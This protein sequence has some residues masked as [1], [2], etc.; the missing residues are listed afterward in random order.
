LALMHLVGILDG[1]LAYRIN[2]GK[3]LVVTVGALMGALV[4][5]YIIVLLGRYVRGLRRLL[6]SWLLW[7]PSGTICETLGYDCCWLAFLK[8]VDTGRFFNIASSGV[9]ISLGHPPEID[10]LTELSGG[11]LFVSALN[12][13]EKEELGLHSK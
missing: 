1:I 10:R 9:R 7:C 2:L 6:A 13:E 3:G 12:L 8:P 11:F 4:V 5:V